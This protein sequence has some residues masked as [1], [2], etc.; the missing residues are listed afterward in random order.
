MNA[1]NE[2]EDDLFSQPGDQMQGN[3]SQNIQN[4]FSQFYKTQDNSNVN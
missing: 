4:E 1:I 2:N 3:S